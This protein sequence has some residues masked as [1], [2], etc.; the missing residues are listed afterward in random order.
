MLVNRKKDHGMKNSYRVG[1]FDLETLIDEVFSDV[2][3][4]WNDHVRSGESQ[5]SG[6]DLL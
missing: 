6:V 1:K 4:N 2:L 3:H 5:G